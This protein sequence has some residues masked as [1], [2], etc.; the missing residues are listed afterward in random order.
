MFAIDDGEDLDKV[1]DKKE[2]KSVI[3]TMKEGQMIS[4]EVVYNTFK[5]RVEEVNY[6]DPKKLEGLVEEGR[7]I[8]KFF[9]GEKRQFIIDV[10]TGMKEFLEG[11]QQK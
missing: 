5:Q 1:E 6:E 4:K 2:E 9:E 11:K 3:E 10:C 8:L 7:R